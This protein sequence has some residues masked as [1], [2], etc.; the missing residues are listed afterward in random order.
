MSITSHR[1]LTKKPPSSP[2]VERLLKK[3]YEV[4]YLTDAV[5]EYCISALPEFDGKRFQNVAKDGLKV[6]QGEK[7]K[8]RLE[9]LKSDFE[10]LTKW[11][12]TQVFKDKVAKVVLSQRLQ[13]SPCAL[14]ANQFGWTGNM[15]RLARSNAHAKTNDIT[16]EYVL[17]IDSDHF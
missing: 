3:G 2:F 10:P 8:E 9:A 7:A 1:R 4:L 16:R 14:V 6:D 5:D 12:E 11:M 13:D 17:L 15:E